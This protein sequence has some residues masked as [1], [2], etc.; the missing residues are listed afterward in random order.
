LSRFVRP[1]AYYFSFGGEQHLGRFVS[2]GLLAAGALLSRASNDLFDAFQMCR[3]LVATWMIA[4]RTL[5]L[6]SIFDDDDVVVS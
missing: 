4:T 1:R 3:Q 6:L 5:L 2:N